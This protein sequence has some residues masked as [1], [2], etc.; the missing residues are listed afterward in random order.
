MNLLVSG[1]MYDMPPEAESPTVQQKLFSLCRASS[2]GKNR[3]LLPNNKKL[4]LRAL[5]SM[6]GGGVVSRVI[7]LGGWGK[8]G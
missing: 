4:T 8:A 7:V 3:Q 6:L 1:P 2:K 5:K